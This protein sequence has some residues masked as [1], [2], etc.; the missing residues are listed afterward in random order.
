MPKP[1][2]RVD[3]LVL[4]H[5]EATIMMHED[6]VNRYLASRPE[7]W[8][9]VPWLLPGIL[10]PSAQIRISDEKREHR[11][12]EVRGGGGGVCDG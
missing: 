2:Y 8:P 11:R 10:Q 7:H 3:L 1:I 6:G 4:F 5:P 12:L 9:F